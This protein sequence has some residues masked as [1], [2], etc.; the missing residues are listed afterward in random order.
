MEKESK[1]P[2]RPIVLTFKVSEAEDREV[3]LTARAEQITL[4]ELIRQSVRDRA[5]RLVVAGR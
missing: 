1:L 5:E 2:H 4:S 3:R